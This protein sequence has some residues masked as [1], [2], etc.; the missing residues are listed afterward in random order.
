MIKFNY[1]YILMHNIICTNINN[2]SYFAQMV[3]L[4]SF[5]MVFIF[6]IFLTY[7]A[8]K[9]ISNYGFK[10]NKNC[11]I[12]ILEVIGVSP[13]KTLQLIKVGSKVI[14]VAVTKDRVEYI[15]EINENEINLESKIESNNFKEQLIKYKNIL[16]KDKYTKW[17]R[18]NEK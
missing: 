1:A 13:Q 6:V 7:Y 17:R 14:L 3:T 12:K 18:G 2:K 16:K 15:T 5:I 4:V 10:N 11:N 9:L 8:T